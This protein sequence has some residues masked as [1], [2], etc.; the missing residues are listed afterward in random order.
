MAWL[1]V[2]QLNF[3]GFAYLGSNVKI[4]DKAS[5]YGAELISIGDNSRIDDFAVISAGQGGIKIGRNVHIAIFAS[6]IGAA[7]ITLADFSGLSSR[8]SV[9]SSSDDYS[10]AA[11]TNPTVPA[12]YTKILSKPVYIGRHVVVGSGSVILPGVSIADGCAIGALALVNK[13]CRDISIYS[14]VPAKPIMRRRTTFLELEDLYLKKEP[15]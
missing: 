12:D 1:S 14:G 8:V 10:G 13:D 7:K 6:L 2:D 3:M 15:G 11:M 4:S 5:I 9:Y